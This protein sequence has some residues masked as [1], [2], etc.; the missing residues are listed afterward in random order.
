MLTL[1][2]LPGLRERVG[3]ELGTGAWHEVTQAHIDAFAGATD[4]HTKIHVDPEHARQ[5]PFG[6]TIAHGLYT[7]SLGPKFIH[8]LYEIVGVG[9]GLNY[10]FNRVRFITPVPSGSRVRMR[11]R[12]LAVEDLDRLPGEQYT[13]GIQAVIEQTFEI[14]GLERPACVAESVVRYFA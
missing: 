14:E 13:E 6:S 4:D 3:E 7:L 1:N 8:E 5:T 12:I 11:A 10:G 2:G 9:L